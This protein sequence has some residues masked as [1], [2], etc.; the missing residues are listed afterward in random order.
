MASMQI[1]APDS[2]TK[3][4]APGTRDPA[5]GWLAFC[6]MIR[7]QACAIVSSLNNPE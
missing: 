1:Q 6:D 7:L 3:G 4:F 5:D 2:V